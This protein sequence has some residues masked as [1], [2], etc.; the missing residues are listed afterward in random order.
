M[1]Q[2]T[3]SIKSTKKRYKYSGKNVVR[4]AKDISLERIRGRTCKSNHR[5]C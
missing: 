3:L 5:H 2:L 1:K 4:H